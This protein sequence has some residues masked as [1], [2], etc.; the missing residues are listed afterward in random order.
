M[1]AAGEAPAKRWYTCVVVLRNE[2]GQLV[3]AASFRLLCVNG[4]RVVHV[5]PNERC[6]EPI[7]RCLKLHQAQALHRLERFCDLVVELRDVVQL[8]D[9]NAHPPAQVPIVGHATVGRLAEG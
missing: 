3:D 2:T 1:F 8:T 4:H 9:L 5:A 7:E 6:V